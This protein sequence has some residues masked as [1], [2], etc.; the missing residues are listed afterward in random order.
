MIYSYITVTNSYVE[1]SLLE[2]LLGIISLPFVEASSLLTFHVTLIIRINNPESNSNSDL[3][4]EL[5]DSYRQP[6]MKSSDG[7][8]HKPA[9][10]LLLLNVAGSIVNLNT[11]GVE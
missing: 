2:S 7:V 3:V 10:S 9:F 8:P 5:S 1:N 11:I 4:E 6:P